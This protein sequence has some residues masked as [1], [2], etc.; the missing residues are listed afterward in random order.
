VADPLSTA[1]LERLGK[2]L[3][4]ESPPAEADLQVLHELLAARSELLDG[5]IVRV[6]DQLGLDLTSRVKNTGTI[7]EKLRRQGGWRLG[8]MQDVAGMRI[9]GDF[10]R[11]GQDDVVADLVRVFSDAERAPKIIDRRAEPMHGYRA[12]HVI[13]FP[14]G[15]PLEIQVRTPW[16]HEWAEVFEKLADLVGRGIRYGEPPRPPTTVD[17]STAAALGNIAVALVEGVISLSTY[18]D[19]VEVIQAEGALPADEIA[20]FDRAM[21]KQ[22]EFVERLAA[23]L[24]TQGTL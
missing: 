5:A 21:A 12:V 20:D 18:L 22:H 4:A 13:V 17:E 2:R 23:L 15:V 14:S 3:I 11:R 9:V 19:I 24:S 1:Q 10:D 6:K 8:S 16:Q 7:L